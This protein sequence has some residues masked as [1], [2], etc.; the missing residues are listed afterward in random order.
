LTNVPIPPERLF[1]V[2]HIDRTR[3]GTVISRSWRGDP[4][5]FKSGRSHDGTTV[6]SY[7]S[8]VSGSTISTQGK[9]AKSVSRVQIRRTPC[10]RISTAVSASSRKL[11]LMTGT[12]ATA[13]AAIAPNYCRQRACSGALASAAYT[14]TLVSTTNT[15]RPSS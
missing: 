7:G 3:S 6:P 8:P 15:Y 14:N 10:S 4:S 1:A 5:R 13:Y 2:N 12:A 11:A 9:R